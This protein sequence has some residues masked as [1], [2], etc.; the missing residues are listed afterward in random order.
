M[1]I[2][3][4]AQVTVCNAGSE[5]VRT[6]RLLVAE[7]Q[8]RFQGQGA[9]QRRY[10]SGWQ[11]LCRS[12][13]P[14]GV[15]EGSAAGPSASIKLVVIGDVHGQWNEA[16]YPDMAAWELC[17]KMMAIAL[18]PSYTSLSSQENTQLFMDAI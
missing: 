6:T 17:P 11:P 3:R 18:S 9:G 8:L 12:C 2:G 4:P 7:R 1:L 13:G 16:R 10:R 5:L 14:M 15:Q